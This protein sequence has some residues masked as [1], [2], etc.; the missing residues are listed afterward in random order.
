MLKEQVYTKDCFIWIAK[1]CL[2][3]I[4]ILETTDKGCSQRKIVLGKVHG[5]ILFQG[6]EQCFTVFLQKE[7]QHI[8]KMPKASALICTRIGYSLE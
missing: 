1:E 8:K 3:E 6:I 7:N 5:L 2:Q 4:S